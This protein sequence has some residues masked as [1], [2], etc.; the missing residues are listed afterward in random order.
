MSQELIINW[1]GRLSD[2]VANRDLN[3]HMALVSKKVTVYGVPK[4]HRIDYTG[5]KRR[6]RNE[7]TSE[8]LASLSYSN[9]TIKTIT[10]KRLGFEIIETMQAASGRRIIIEKDVMLEQEEDNEWRVVEEKIR[11]WKLA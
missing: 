6:R 2:S 7:L 9:L 4:H 3:A 8:K 11:S 5:W 1:L 10:L